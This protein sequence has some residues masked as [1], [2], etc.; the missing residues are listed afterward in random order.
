MMLE[1]PI[2]SEERYLKPGPLSNKLIVALRRNSRVFVGEKAYRVKAI[3][4]SEGGTI[5]GRLVPLD[6]AQA[7]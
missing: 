2:S 6:N 5:M 7:N 1:E 4:I 3:G